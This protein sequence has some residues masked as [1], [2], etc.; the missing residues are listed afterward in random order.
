MLRNLTACC[1]CLCITELTPTA[2]P[3]SVFVPAGL[4]PGDVYQ[5]AFVTTGTTTATSAVIQDYNAFVNAQGALSPALTGTN[6][7]VTWSA[8]GSTTTVNAQT[9]AFVQAPVYLLNSTQ[10]ATGFADFWDGSLLTP[11]NIDQFGQASGAT[12]AWTGSFFDG[13]V[14]VPPGY[15]LGG[16]LG[17]AR[18]GN[19]QKSNVEW[20]FDGLGYAQTQQFPMYALSNPLTV[21]PEPASHF[22]CL[23]WVLAAFCC[24]VWFHIADEN[25]GAM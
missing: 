15:A 9:N 23:G 4:N 25:V 20:V 22:I 19:P 13:T 10:I 21:V 3:A 8:I 12:I 14:S 6:M 1:C 5:L 2:L 18:S 17:L 24:R 16:A 7:G 11:L